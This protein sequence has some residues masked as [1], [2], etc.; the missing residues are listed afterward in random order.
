MATQQHVREGDFNP[1]RLIPGSAIAKATS[2]SGTEAWKLPQLSPAGA[3][4]R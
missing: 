1:G 4:P 3:A 2:G